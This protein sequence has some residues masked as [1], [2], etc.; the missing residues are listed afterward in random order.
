MIT[1]PRSLPVILLATG[2]LF[3]ATAGGAVAG[4]L[5]TGAQIKDNTVTSADIKN[6]T[7]GLTD[8]SSSAQAA[9]AGRTGPAGPAGAAGPAGPAGATGPAGTNG[10]NGVS[11][12]QRLTFTSVVIPSNQNGTVQGS[13]PPGKKL[14]GAA[15]EWANQFSGAGIRVVSDG[16]AVGRGSNQM[17]FDDSLILTIFCAAVS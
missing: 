3:L 4:K 2:A 11:N 13:C 10:S 16:T 6:R 17:W 5:I 8:I 12:W 9:L 14:T 15:I 7:L 1:L